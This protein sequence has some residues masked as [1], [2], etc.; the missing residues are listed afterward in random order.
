MTRLRTRTAALVAAVALGA[1]AGGYV[2]SVHQQP[3]P[4]VT[5]AAQTYS[6][7]RPMSG[8]NLLF[9]ACIPRFTGPKPVILDNGSHGNAGCKG[10]K[11]N[12]AGRLE[13]DLAIKSPRCHPVLFSGVVQDDRM[14]GK[15]GAG[16]TLG[17]SGGTDDVELWAFDNA[18]GRYLDLNKKADYDRL[19]G[20]STNAWYMSIHSTATGSGCRT[21]GLSS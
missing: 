11:V 16:V 9:T 15:N 17:T 20:A 3:A 5:P 10:I 7:N 8:S 14:V 12:E 2:A 18:K 4:T 6:P 19:R 21:D 13:I 1:S